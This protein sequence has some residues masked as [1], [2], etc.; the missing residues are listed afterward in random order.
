MQEVYIKPNKVKFQNY[1]FSE[2]T[3]YTFDSNSVLFVNFGTAQVMIND[4]FPLG[5]SL[6]PGL[7]GA[8]LNFGANQNEVD[9]TPYKIT[10]G[11]TGTRFLA[12]I[13]KEDAGTAERV[14]P[15]IT[16]ENSA[17]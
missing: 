4:V 11:T 17:F 6:G 13:V 7:I 9:G 15:E 1:T 10:F 8:T 16:K 2:N 5:G 14:Y 3:T 12:A